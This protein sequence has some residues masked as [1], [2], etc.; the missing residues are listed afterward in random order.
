MT[1]LV[2]LAIIASACGTAEASPQRAEVAPSPTSTST[3]TTTSTSTSTS[4]T[5]S[6]PPTTIPNPHET[7][8]AA[9]RSSVT[10]LVAYDSPNGERISLP[11]QV[12][13]PHQFGGPLTLMVTEGAK[14][15]DWVKVQ[16]PIRPNGTEAWIP[17]ADYRISSTVIWAEVDLSTTSVKVFSDGDLIQESQAAI[18]AEETPTPIGTF[19]VAAKRLNP[20]EEAHLGTWALVLSSFSETLP[21]FSGGLPV[22]AIHGE[23]D[24]DRVLG[25]AISNGCV[26]VSNEVIQFLAAYVPLGA[27]VIISA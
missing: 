7:L 27:P 5:S 2:M 12:P 26:R 13:N 3:S 8:T 25:E 11:F 6:T 14:D 18:G 24:P 16:L 15:D 19:Y 23:N 10:S 4:T 20:P 1:I 22:I 9:A 21:S 17:T